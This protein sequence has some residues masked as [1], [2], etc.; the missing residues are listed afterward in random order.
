[1]T[2]RPWIFLNNTFYSNTAK[3]MKNALSLTQDHLAKLTANETDADIL[4]IKTGYLPVHNAFI[5][6]NN[7]LDSKLGIYK[8]KTQTLEEMMVELSRVKINEWR[9]PVFA[10]FPEGTDNATAI[11]PR[12]RQPFQS[13]TYDER[14]EAV[15][16]L[17]LTLATYTTQP[18]L[19]ALSAT[20]QAY[21]ITLSGARALQQSNEGTVA[22]L[23][24]NLKAAHVLMCEGMYK[25][26][27][28][29]MAKYYQTPDTI[30]DYF[31]LTLLRNT[32]GG[33]TIVLDGNINSTQVLNLN[34]QIDDN[35]IDEN[36]VIVMKNTSASAT[37]L[38]F[39]AADAPDKKPDGFVS[40]ILN[41]GEEL[42][43]TIADIGFTEVNTF[44]NIYNP[45]S[46]AGSWVV[47]VEV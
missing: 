27:G 24:T 16:S 37:Q 8:G 19:V 33:E 17:S 43:R 29:L 45:G 15:N 41:P 44:F 34:G 18:T 1:M 26:L 38:Y 23:R 3:S 13:G 30:A 9:G 40:V 35:N 46:E 39:Y 31:D 28:L 12:E 21:Y 11:F 32:G 25:N 42:S 6:A 2:T 10:V 22:T 36:T 4:A 47:E 5:T 7:Q 14:I 20:V